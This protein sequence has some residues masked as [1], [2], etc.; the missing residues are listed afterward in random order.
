MCLLS[1]FMLRKFSIGRFVEAQNTRVFY[2]LISKECQMLKIERLVN[3]E[4][5]Y[6]YVVIGFEVDDCEF[7]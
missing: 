1:R 4:K 3:V 2:C 5:Y 7:S 6:K